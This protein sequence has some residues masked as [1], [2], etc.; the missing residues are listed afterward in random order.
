MCSCAEDL[1]RV[2][3]VVN[4][5]PSG[6]DSK[7]SA[8]PAHHAWAY[9]IGVSCR[10]SFLSV[11]IAVGTHIVYVICTH[12]S[13]GSIQ[14]GLAEKRKIARA[15]VGC[16]SAPRSGYHSSCGSLEGDASPSRLVREDGEAPIAFQVQSTLPDNFQLPA[17]HRNDGGSDPDRPDLVR[18]STSSVGAS[19]DT[20]DYGGDIGT[21]A[22]GAKG[23]VAQAFEYAAVDMTA[24]TCLEHVW[25]TGRLGLCGPRGQALG[26]ATFGRL[27]KPR[28]GFSAQMKRFHL[29]TYKYRKATQELK[30]ARFAC[31]WLF[32]A[33]NPLPANV[34][35]HSWESDQK[36][37]KR[38][39]HDTP[40]L[41]SYKLSLLGT[42]C[43]RLKIPSFSR[44]LC[45]SSSKGFLFLGFST[46]L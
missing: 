15:D 33:T 7:T 25:V 30:V 10:R 5:C 42:L 37:R 8:Q 4:V 40:A 38:E 6:E 46:T 20:C 22:Q 16:S 9:L 13:F 12:K 41:L 35:K 27:V 24:A 1:P 28:S 3:G 39:R 2:H 21:G 34:D 23:V 11:N 17:A 18:I 14:R 32:C 43:L 19:P 26:P 45:R 44:A 31:S 29:S 36:A